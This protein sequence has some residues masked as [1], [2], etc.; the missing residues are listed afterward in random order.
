MLS[1][2]ERQSEPHKHRA[3]MVHLRR[4]ILTGHFMPG[5]RMATCREL[6][7]KLDASRMAVTY[8]LDHHRATLISAVAA[9]MRSGAGRQ[10]ALLA[11]RSD[12]DA[13][14]AAWIEANRIHT[15]VD[16]STD[17]KAPG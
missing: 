14:A 8:F 13:P 11:D 2:T 16:S 12:G 6:A 4:Q 10:C 7:S 3:I 1:R 15:S 5:S 17:G 9:P